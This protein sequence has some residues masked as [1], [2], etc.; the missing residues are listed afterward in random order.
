MIKQSNPFNLRHFKLEFRQLF[1]TSFGVFLFILFFQP[2]P[3]EALSH[4]NRLLYVFGFFG[5]TFIL[6]AFI[7]VFLPIILHNIKKSSITETEPASALYIILV[8]VCVTAYTFYIR[9]VGK[10]HLNLYLLFRITLVCLIPVILLSIVYKNKSLQQRISFY[11]QHMLELTKKLSHYKDVSGDHKIELFSSNKAD[12]LQVK[13]NQIIYI[14]SA[15]NYIEIHYIEHDEL[16]SK[17]LRNTLKAI[18][19]QLLEQGIIFRCHRTCLVNKL[20]IKQLKSS[21]KGYSLQIQ[22]FDSPLP[23]AKQYV[24]TIKDIMEQN[25]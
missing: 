13:I 19:Y 2:F 8:L 10:T 3:L 9:Y 20:Y 7:L 23:V 4:E 14:K 6:A 5:I 1:Y 15:D 11:Q 17:L 24:A 21:Y 25:T 22:Y 18:E 12:K 16:K